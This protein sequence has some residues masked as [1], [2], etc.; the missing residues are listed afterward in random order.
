MENDEKV[1][2]KYN[3]SKIYTIRCTDNNNLIYVGATTQPLY[4]RWYQHKK[5][6]FYNNVKN[7]NIL[8]Y[9]KIRELGLN[10]FYIE[11]YENFKCNNKE[12]LTKRE[13]DV[14]RQIAT[15]NKCISGRKKKEY[16]QDN[17]EVIQFKK[18]EYYQD[19]KEE[20]K[21]KRKEYYKV[22]NEEV[23]LKRKEYYEANKD[24]VKEY[25]KIYYKSNKLQL[26]NGCINI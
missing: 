3:N 23:K 19:N 1:I 22:N 16:Y 7:I 13:G 17:K 11:L 20:I 21:L 24:K 18:K 5:V 14:I 2:N 4:K 12:E 26:K 6:C 9:I 10:K 25:N 8:L 15:L